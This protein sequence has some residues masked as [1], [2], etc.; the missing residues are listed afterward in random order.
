[1]KAPHTISV[2]G[3]LRVAFGG[4]KAGGVGRKGGLEALSFSRRRRMFAL[5]NKLAARKRP[6]GRAVASANASFFTEPKR[7]CIA[8]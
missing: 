4:M 7:I 3:D 8:K 5:L 6:A 2:M 1:M